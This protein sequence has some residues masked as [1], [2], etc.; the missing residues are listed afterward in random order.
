M[1]RNKGFTLIEL[2]A[3]ITILA[4]VALITVPAVNKAITKSKDKAYE[5]QKNAIVA[6]A[7]EW[8][9]ENIGSNLGKTQ[10]NYDVLFI[11]D[12]TGSMSGERF[13][14]TVN[15]TNQILQLLMEA[16]ENNKVQIVLF[17]D[18]TY[19]FFELDH[20]TAGP[21]GNFLLTTSSSSATTAAGVTNSSGTIIS[22]T[23][24]TLGCT[25]IQFGIKDGIVRFINS[26]KN[27]GSSKDVPAVILLTDGDPCY[28][29]DDYINLSSATE[30]SSYPDILYNIVLTAQY[31]KD[32]LSVETEKEASFYTVGLDLTNE[33]ALALLDPVPAKLANYT[34]LR[35]MLES[36][37]NPIKPYNYADMSFTGANMTQEDILNIFKTAL[38]DAI[39][40]TGKLQIQT[41]VDD[42]YIAESA[43][44][45][46]RTG[47]EMD[48]Y[49]NVTYDEVENKYIYEYIEN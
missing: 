36:S 29:F 46:P 20:Y 7:K 47:E 44:V 48:G 38:A 9:L 28:S 10:V 5:T 2:I 12:I 8:N 11:L 40:D 25:N 33:D 6:A 21:D 32:L 1:K 27:S 22:D 4:V 43:L 24:E 35:D 39:S 18:T 23:F 16:N 3:V 45:D 13:I 19:S 42:G 30:T 14:S 34:E 26:I 49:I 41:L 37:S 17:A 15:A 31:Y